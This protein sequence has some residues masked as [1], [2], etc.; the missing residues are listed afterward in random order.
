M[1]DILSLSQ[2][3]LRN[4]INRAAPGA[5]DEQTL[6]KIS[7]SVTQN[8]LAS[9]GAQTEAQMAAEERRVFIREKVSTMLDTI[10][11]AAIARELD[12][13][14]VDPADHFAKTSGVLIDDEGMYSLLDA[15]EAYKEVLSEALE[16]GADA[17][18]ALAEILLEAAAEDPELAAELIAEA[19]GTD[20]DA[21]D[22]DGMAAGMAEEA[23][24]PD[25]GSTKESQVRLEQ[26]VKISSGLTPWSNAVIESRARRIIEHWQNQ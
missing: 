5:L 11:A 2:T 23:L 13:H 4:R 26:L 15:A 21:E 7:A 1:S 17:E 22:V 9:L 6:A 20:V 14:G 16:E 3:D 19:E 18:E 12:R 25:S 10:C 24:D 8:V